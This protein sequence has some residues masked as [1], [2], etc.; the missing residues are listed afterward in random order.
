MTRCHVS[1]SDEDQVPPRPLTS[2]QCPAHDGAAKPPTTL[3]SP[4]VVPKAAAMPQAAQQVRGSR[5][6]GMRATVTTR[7]AA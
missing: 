1:Q 4:R 7:L 5:A 2:T 6:H 3:S